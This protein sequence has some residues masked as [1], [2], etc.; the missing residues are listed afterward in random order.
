[1][2]DVGYV[3]RE[4]HNH[5]DTCG[6]H[7]PAC[8]LLTILRHLTDRAAHAALA[9]AVRAAVVQLDAIRPRI[10]DAPDNLSPR[11]GFGLNHRGN[12]HRAIGPGTLDLGNLAQIDIQG[13]V[14]N[15]FDV[16]DGQHPLA[17]VMPGSVA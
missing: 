7:H 1:Q 5:R 16:V 9:H 13:P 17:A 15:Q 6:L 12:D 10:F 2:H 4:L 8:D 14:G 3:G 11:L